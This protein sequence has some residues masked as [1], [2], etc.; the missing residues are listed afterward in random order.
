MQDLY[1]AYQDGNNAFQI[2]FYG[3]GVL[4]QTAKLTVFGL[5]I[6]FLQLQ[7]T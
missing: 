5:A 2:G 1:S 4:P 3:G 6:T 7:E